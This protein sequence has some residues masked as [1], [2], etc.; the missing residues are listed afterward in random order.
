MPGTGSARPGTLRGDVPPKGYGQGE[1]LKR[2]HVTDIRL[3]ALLRI[4]TM[5]RSR[6]INS[7]YAPCVRPAAVALTFLT[8]AT[9]CGRVHPVTSLTRTSPTPPVAPVYQTLCPAQP[10]PCS[11]VWDADLV[12]G[13]NGWILMG[14]CT[15]PPTGQCQF[16]VAGTVD[17]GFMWSAPVKVG[18]VFTTTDGDAPRSIHFLNRLDGFVY[19][20]EVAFVTHDGGRTWSN[21]ALKVTEVVTIAGRGSMSWAVTYPCAKGTPCPFNVQSSADGG[22]TWSRPHQLADGSSPLDAIPFGSKGVVV[23]TMGDMAL[24]PDGGATWRQVKSRCPFAFRNYVA[25]SDGRELWQMCTSNWTGDSSDKALLVS[26]DGGASWSQRASSQGGGAL[27]AAGS[28]ATFLSTG[29]GTAFLATDRTPIL[30][31]HDGGVTWMQVAP[32]PSSSVYP[33]GWA[34]AAIRFA[35]G[36]DAWALDF[37]RTIWATHDGGANWAQL[38]A[39]P[40]AA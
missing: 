26:E 36:S 35:T 39:L 8:M 20:R 16:F 14:L 22:R 34:F 27:P 7:W 10:A 17:G 12:D 23:S 5:T 19:G 38:P 32:P 1:G 2:L 4:A 40:V 25:T 28:P 30:V 21:S 13:S 31:T 9:A 15:Q 33:K 24:T 37:Q 29:L 18:P 11:F 6:G 3:W